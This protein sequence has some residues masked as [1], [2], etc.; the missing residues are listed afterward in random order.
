MRTT[1]LLV[2][3]TSGCPV[4]TGCRCSLERALPVRA[5]EK[6]L[7]RQVIYSQLRHGF[8]LPNLQLWQL[9][10]QHVWKR[11]RQQVCSPTTLAPVWQASANRWPS[12]SGRLPLH[13]SRKLQ[14]LKG[15]TR[16][17]AFLVQRSN[18]NMRSR[19]NCR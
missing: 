1:E 9:S 7:S 16:C 19:L 3:V 10:H 15:S 11:R 6:A 17:L 12:N 4:P 2:G 8:V 18:T 5:L 13:N 14:L